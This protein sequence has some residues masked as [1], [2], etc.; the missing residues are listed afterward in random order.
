AIL[1]QSDLLAV[2]VIR[3]AEAR[4]HA[5][6]GDLSVTGFDGVRIDGLDGYDLTTM[7][8]PVAEKGRAAGHAVARLLAGPDEAAG[9]T[10][11]VFSCEFHRGD[12]TA[13]PA[14]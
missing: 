10:S 12:T 6:P 8:Q 7:R 13:A 3:E 9:V 1:A 11:A 2:G 14:R 5:V 4:G